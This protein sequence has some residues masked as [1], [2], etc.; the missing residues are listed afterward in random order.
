MQIDTPARSHT[1]TIFAPSNFD[2]SKVGITRKRFST[3]QGE[4]LL[5]YDGARIGQYG[6]DPTLSPDGTYHQRDATFWTGIALREALA[7]GVLA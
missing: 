6:D 3:T 2:P 1:M 5:T 4:T 7:Q